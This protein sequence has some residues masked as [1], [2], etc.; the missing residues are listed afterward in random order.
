M[1]LLKGVALIVGI[2]LILVGI[3]ALATGLYALSGGAGVR[4][5]LGGEVTAEQYGQIV[6]PVGIVVLLI[7]IGLSYFSLKKKKGERE[8]A[9]V[10]ESYEKLSRLLADNK[11]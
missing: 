2:G 8:P 6:T 9:L 5:A 7:G 1:G 4:F 10:P 11:R 3:V